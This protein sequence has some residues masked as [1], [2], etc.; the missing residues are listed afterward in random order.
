MLRPVDKVVGARDTT[1][2]DARFREP[3]RG[4]ATRVLVRRAIRLAAQLVVFLALV[5]VMF[6]RIPQ[7]EGRSMLPNIEDGDH[8]LINTLAYGLTVGSLTLGAHG[9]ARGDIVAFERGRGDDRKLFLKRVIALPGDRVEIIDG[10]VTIDGSRFRETY[11]YFMDHS[12][13]PPLVVPKDSVFVLGDNRAESDDS[14]LF[15]PV[16]RVSI[17]GKA[18]FV[19]W[20]IGNA[21]ALR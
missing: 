16:P 4:L 17:L 2:S 10:K 6:L 11:D 3:D 1:L 7:V 20:P 14:R 12:N 21:K 8:V 5:L 18:L 9:I 19:I 13:S 15:G